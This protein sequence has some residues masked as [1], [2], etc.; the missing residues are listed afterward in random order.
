M[1][2]CGIAL[3]LTET[4]IILLAICEQALTMKIAI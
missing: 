1:V 4:R 3:I 2:V